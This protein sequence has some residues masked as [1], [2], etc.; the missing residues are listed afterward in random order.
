MLQSILQL[1]LYNYIVGQKIMPQIEEG[2]VFKN[3]FIANLPL[4][5][6]VKKF[7]KL[8]NIWQRYR[9]KYSRL[10]VSFLWLTV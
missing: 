9:Q 7:W 1:Q 2:G 8:V 4:S 6:P 5:L 10:F 3:G